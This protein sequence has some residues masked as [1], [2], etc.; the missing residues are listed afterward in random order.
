MWK[1]RSLLAM[2]NKIAPEDE[3]GS[4]GETRAR[5]AVPAS[6]PGWMPFARRGGPGSFPAEVPWRIRAALGSLLASAVVCATPRISPIADQEVDEDTST[7]ALPFTVDDPKTPAGQFTVEAESSDAAL[8]PR[9]NLVL[10]GGGSERTVRISPATNRFGAA[11]ITLTVRSATG[12]YASNRFTF[13]VRPVNDAPTFGEEPPIFAKPG[14]PYSWTIDVTDSDP[15]DRLD[16]TAAELP[17]W[18]SLDPAARVLSGVPGRGGPEGDLVVLKVRDSAGAEAV[19]SF[20][21]WTEDNITVTNLAEVASRRQS[22]IRYIWGN[23]G[24]PTNRSLTLVQGHCWD[25]YEGLNTEEGNL[26]RVD[27]YACPL[28]VEAGLDSWIFHFVPRRAN[29]R[30]FIVHTGHF[31]GGF[32]DQDITVNADGQSPGLVIPALL[33]EGYAVLAVDMPLYTCG[34]GLPKRVSLGDRQEVDL[35]GHDD[36]FRYFD[37]PLRYFVEPVVAAVNTLQELYAY[38]HIY[39]AGLSGGGWTTTLC[40][41]LDPRIERSFPVAGSMPNYLRIGFEGLGDAEQDDPG[42]YRIANYEE[43]YVMGAAG[44]NRLQ[45]QILN[46]NDDC[47]FFGTRHTNW[48][49]EVTSVADGLGGGTY[50]F[51]SD[52]THVGHKVSPAALTRI[53]A[54]LP[55][56]VEAP[57]EIAV[58]GGEGE[59]T[60]SLRISTGSLTRQGT[61]VVTAAADD[62]GLLEQVT[63]EY[64]SPSAEGALRFRVASNRWGVATVRLA[65]RGDWSELAT[66]EVRLE[67]KVRRP[68]QP[69]L[70]T[71]A[72]PQPGSVW[73]PGTAIMLA[74]DASDADGTIA[75]V[76][77]WAGSRWLGS[78]TQ[79]PY[80]LIWYNAPV[81]SHDLRATARDDH[82]ALTQ[83]PGVAITVGTLPLIA[84]IQPT[85]E[86]QVEIEIQ[87]PD[88]S[89]VVTWASS[90]LKDWTPVSTNVLIGGGATVVR[91][92]AH[93]MRVYRVE[94]RNPPPGTDDPDPGQQPR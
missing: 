65:V 9:Q 86:G 36:M 92:I 32:M 28:A 34:V 11:F 55:P 40:A 45:L 47:C 29:G 38:R 5:L 53:L 82:G 67:I 31:L 24:W 1:V 60:V 20:R 91:P 18:L 68:N 4:A 37:R 61:V 63:A 66:N 58:E 26:D 89:T 52:D 70:V 14:Q 27:L 10:T 17:A 25:F 73:E 23:D 13:T 77:F 7:P 74:A 71:L 85:T 59:R 57:A 8:V 87:G 46:L 78:V 90:E 64:A 48:V 49:D 81:G 76:E 6:H 39:M 44:S 33:K 54:A 56:E 42:F 80:R 12:E 88:G 83:S 79:P 3:C 15:G 84:R 50:R 19:K 93:P 22:L 41:A 72:A 21:I 62:S 43:L 51:W 94:L 16:L 2:H 35:W 75:G 69:P 30:L